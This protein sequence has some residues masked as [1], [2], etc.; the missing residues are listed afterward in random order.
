MLCSSNR[1][2]GYGR[3]ALNVEA[4]SAPI[5]GSWQLHPFARGRCEDAAERA[6]PATTTH[7]A[8]AACCRA[9]VEA[10]PRTHTLLT[11]V[12]LLLWP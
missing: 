1:C 2:S 4:V 12:A 5:T 7:S 9:C 8:G 10:R 6:P 11:W 3:H